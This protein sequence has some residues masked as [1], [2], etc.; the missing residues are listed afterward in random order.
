MQSIG[1]WVMTNLH[2]CQ[3]NGSPSEHGESIK[4][5]L[6][7][8]HDRLTWSSIGYQNLKTMTLSGLT[9]ISSNNVCRRS[10]GVQLRAFSV[11]SIAQA[12]LPRSTLSTTW[13]PTGG[14]TA[15]DDEC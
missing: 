5:G 4:Q 14:L 12:V 3:S 11:S 9:Q 6:E 7:S 2:W 10:L 1:S 15:N 8:H 13:V